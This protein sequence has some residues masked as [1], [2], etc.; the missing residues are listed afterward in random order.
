MRQSVLYIIISLFIL[1]EGACS[2]LVEAVNA[3]VV[4]LNVSG[5]TNEMSGVCHVSA[6]TCL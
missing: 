2:R 1:V 3:T 5:T 6:L 4:T